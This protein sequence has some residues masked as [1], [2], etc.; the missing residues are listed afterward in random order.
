MHDETRFEELKRYVQF[1]DHDAALLLRFRDVA[2]PEFPRIAQVF[3]DR[4]REHDEA[5][6]VFSS[7]E[8]IHRLQRSL[9][10]WLERVCGGV[11]DDAYCAQTAHIGQTHVR[12]GLPQRYMFTAMALIRLEL[13]AIARREL[14]SD[15]PPTESALSRVLDL[16]LAVMLQAYKDSY[17]DRVRQAERQERRVLDSALARAEHRYVNAVEAA[18]VLI[19][20]LD[21]QGNIQL[22][23]REAERVS[24]RER[25]EL[26]GQ[27]FLAALCIED[28]LGRFPE[29]LERGLSGAAPTQAIEA[30]LQARNGKLRSIAWSLTFGGDAPEDDIVLFAMGT[31]VTDSRAMEE[32]TRQHEKLAAI[33]TLAAGLAHEIRNPLNGAQLHVSF[34]ERAIRKKDA[35]VEMLEATHVV[36]EEIKRLADLV[37]EFLDFAR[38][39]PLQMKEIGLFKLC[40]HVVTLVS[41]QA[42]KADVKLRLD[43]PSS[44]LAFQGDAAK[45]T[46]VL[47]NLT[48][49]AIEACRDNGGGN[50][51]LRGRRNPRH[52]LLDVEDDGPGLAAPDAPIFDAFFSTKD[53]GTGLGL[54]ITHRI[55]SDHGGTIDVTSRP[56]KTIFRVLIPIA[57]SE[58]LNP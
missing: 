30:S 5:H 41:A 12:V 35:D 4:I 44:D 53:G 16:E 18:R 2:R 26:V 3:Y 40:E 29:L 28:D 1:D 25:G 20:G 23:N 32:R 10:K 17:V 13:A 24:G 42:A 21:R 56:A 45:L 34:L 15:A 55:V 50:V 8:Q 54:A 36:S 37:T 49:N 47:L 31:D 46:Q 52:V 19:I 9:V 48:T 14:A 43:L 27:P 38:P 57:H 22:F 39:K 7:E 6:A 33:G 58:N 11:Y 51:C